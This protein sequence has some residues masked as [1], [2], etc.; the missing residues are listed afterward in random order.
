MRANR[1]TC[2]TERERAVLVAIMEGKSAEQIA[3][4]Q[5]VSLSTVRTQ[6]RFLLM[7]LGVRSQLAAVALANRAMFTD[8]ERRERFDMAVSQ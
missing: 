1:L 4:E 7:K 2:L 3:V 5:Y 6:I 8:E